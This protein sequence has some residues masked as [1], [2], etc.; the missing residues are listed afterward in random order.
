VSAHL[1]PAPDTVWYFFSAFGDYLFSSALMWL[2]YLALEP[3]LRARWPQAIITWN[4]LLSGKF[5]DEQLGSHILL[6]VFL[7]IFMGWVLFLRSYWYASGQD[8]LSLSSNLPLMGTR[9]WINQLFEHLNTA[10]WA[11]LLTC[12]MLFGLKQI[13]KWNWLVAIIASVILTLRED[14]LSSSNV[15]IVDAVI[16]I[17][18]F[19]L[20]FYCIIRYGL[21][22]AAI[23]LLTINALGGAS[24]SADFNTWFAPGGIATAVLIGGLAVFG[25]WR[26]MGNQ[27]FAPLGG[28]P[29]A[30]IPSM[31][32][33]R[34]IS[35]RQPS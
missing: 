28:G 16:Y 3:M 29:A 7:G 22:S 27:E 26:S 35:G 4:R 12:F 30:K 8:T 10:I 9:G 15:P 6:G 25:F 14:R 24:L 13:V 31:A 11:G 23:L 21:V 17:G 2:L 20:L 19:M 33:N 5:L 34:E 32:A 1:L 18:L